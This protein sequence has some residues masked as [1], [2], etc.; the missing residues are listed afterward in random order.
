MLL[1]RIPSWITFVSV[2]LHYSG[3]Y[4]ER[5]SQLSSVI[6][7]SHPLL[8]IKKLA[9]TLLKKKEKKKTCQLLCIYII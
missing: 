4:L 5:D 7:T 9:W 1:S 6:T 3:E 2:I 8:R